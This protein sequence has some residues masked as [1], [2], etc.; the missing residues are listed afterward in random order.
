MIDFAD[1]TASSPAS[2][3]EIK[4]LI[5]VVCSYFKVNE[6]DLLSNSRKQELVYAR[7]I[8]WY[9]LKTQYG[10]TF[11][12]IGSLFGGK[13]H[14][15]VMHGCDVIEENIK[16]DNKTK[17]NVENILRRMDKGPNAID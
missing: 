15:T 10:L 12:K 7:Q 9:L 11:K 3:E 14:S 13:D 4:R 2:N 16:I 1:I 17:L 8:C 6:T 5:G